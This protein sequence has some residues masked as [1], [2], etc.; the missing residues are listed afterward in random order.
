MTE[1]N[2]LHD[3][4][5]E[6]FTRQKLKITGSILQFSKFYKEFF[7]GKRLFKSIKKAKLENDEDNQVKETEDQIRQ[8]TFRRA[9][10]KL[11]DYINTNVFAWTNETGY[12][13]PS[14]FLTLTFVDNITDIEIANEEFTAFIRRLNY[15]ITNS[16]KAY[17]KYVV[18]IEFQKR[19][20]VHY[21]A[22]F[23]N[24]PFLEKKRI[25]AIWGNG[26]IKIKA[27][28]DVKDVGFYVTKYMSKNFDDDRLKGHKCYFVSD[29]LI[30]PTVIYFEELINVVKTLLPKEAQ[31]AEKL[32][33][34]VKYLYSMDYVRYNLKKFPEALDETKKFLNSHV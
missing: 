6:N 21:H 14:V 15:E 20:A 2:N 32:N 30:K 31:E 29:G 19:G 13:F 27:I 28:D 5:P 12:I 17:L 18:V 22:I 11:V 8:R 24:L 26:W 1:T 16:I 10:N 4:Q 34:P 9:K 3:L 33:V 7:I 23:F 25:E